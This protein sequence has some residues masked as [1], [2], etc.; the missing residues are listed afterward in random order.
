MVR[1]VVSV[2]AGEG[3]LGDRYRALLGVQ[4]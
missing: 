3:R 4:P 1:S 2:S